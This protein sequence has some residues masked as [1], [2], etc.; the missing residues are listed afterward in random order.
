MNPADRLRGG[1]NIVHTDMRVIH[2]VVIPHRLL[3]V[4]QLGLHFVFIQKCGTTYRYLCGQVDCLMPQLIEIGQAGRG[5]FPDQ[6]NRFHHA[7]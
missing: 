4:F 3:F 7:S 5:G 1:F 6:I 2:D